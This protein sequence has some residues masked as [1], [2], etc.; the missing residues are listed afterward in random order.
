MGNCN[1]NSKKPH[2]GKVVIILLV[3]IIAHACQ[4]SADGDTPPIK[5]SMISCESNLTRFSSTIIDS[6]NALTQQLDTTDMVWIEGGNFTMGV[7]DDEG[8]SDESPAP[9]VTV[10]GFGMDATEITNALFQKFVDATGYI[11]TAEKKPI[12]RT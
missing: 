6:N 9:I 10:N 12:G 7:A 4:T 3:G 5:D 2:Y 11:T 1:V 8:R